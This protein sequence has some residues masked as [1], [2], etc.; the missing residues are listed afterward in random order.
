MLRQRPPSP[1]LAPFVASLWLGES[2]G[3]ANLEHVLPSGAMHIVLR[4]SGPP[5]RLME[6]QAIGYALIGGARSSFYRKDSC[7][8]ACSIGAVLKPGAAL[9]ILR[10]PAGELAETHTPLDAL[11]GNTANALRERLLH[12][13]ASQRLDI[14]ESALRIHLNHQA[15]LHPAIAAALQSL[16]HSQNI[17]AAVAASGYSHRR[18]NELFRAAVGLTPKVY[19]RV[20]RFHHALKSF[21][22][23]AAW[24]DLAIAAGYSDQAHFCREFHSFAGVTPTEYARILP[25]FPLHLPRS[26]S[27]N[28]NG[29]H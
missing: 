17:T 13:P 11:W 29:S 26:N 14:F 5:V 16:P 8:P 15:A 3:K 27:F 2:G 28:T 7:A 23:A 1:D 6:Q 19:C 18:F 9:A 22:P 25:Q 4:L 21:K 20:K 24:A 12:T 10:T